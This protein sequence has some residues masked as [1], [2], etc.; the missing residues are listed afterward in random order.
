[1]TRPYITER[2]LMGRKESNQ[3]K[4]KSIISKS[5]LQMRLLNNNYITLHLYSPVSKNIH[6]FIHFNNVFR[7]VPEDKFKVRRG[8]A[9]EGVSPSHTLEKKS[10]YELNGALSCIF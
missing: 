5:P 7:G 2:L 8:W 9:W 4:S 3:T 1:M 10:R 6:K